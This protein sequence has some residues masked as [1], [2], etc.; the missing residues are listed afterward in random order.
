MKLKEIA[1]RIDCYLKKFEA[2]AKINNSC[3]ST[4]KFW[5]ASA[6]V[7]GR[8]VNVC[9]VNYQGGVNLTKH[10]ALEYLTWLNAGHVG[11]HWKM[12]AQK[13]WDTENS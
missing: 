12:I 9:Y 1:E 2:D 3:V 10:E 13:N 5:L 7:A 11:K 6:T 4:E 8:Y